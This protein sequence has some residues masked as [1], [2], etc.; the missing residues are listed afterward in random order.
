[1]VEIGDAIDA[2]RDVARAERIHEAIAAGP[3]PLVPGVEVGRGEALNVAL[4]R[5]HRLLARPHRDGSAATGRRQH[6]T[7][8]PNDE[9]RTVPVDVQAVVACPIDRERRLGCVDLHG[10]DREIA[11]VERGFAARDLQ[12]ELVRRDIIQLDI[13]RRAESEP[14]GRADLY[15]DVRVAGGEERIARAERCVDARDCPV[16]ATGTP[17]RRLSLHH[18][19]PWR[20]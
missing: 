16:G 17:E 5:H 10:T 6:A 13:G 19:E 3:V 11:Q 1:V 2:I 15:L 8:A 20:G 9:R 18:R 7:T 12:L 14:G 4:A